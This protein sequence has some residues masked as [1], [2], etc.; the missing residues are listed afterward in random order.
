MNVAD[1]PDFD[2]LY[3]LIGD[4]KTTSIE[5]SKLKLQ[6]KVLEKEAFVRGREEGLPVSHVENTYKTTGFNNEI[7][8]LREQLVDAEAELEFMENTL[9]LHKSKIEVWRTVSANERTGIG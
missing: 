6:I 2:E 4:I 5:V 9:E 1:L 7:L 8:P 3:S